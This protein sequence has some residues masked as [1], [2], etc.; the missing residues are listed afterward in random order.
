VTLL[1]FEAK[2]DPTPTLPCKQGREHLSRA[3]A[4]L[5]R[6]RVGWTGFALLWLGLRRRTKRSALEMADHGKTKKE[7]W[8]PACAGGDDELVFARKPNPYASPLPKREQSATVPS[9]KGMTGSASALHPLNND[10]MNRIQPI[11]QRRR[12]RL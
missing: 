8:V 4:P 9:N 2:S 7:H 12:S 5:P 10:S 11:Q 6:N 3:I 1:I